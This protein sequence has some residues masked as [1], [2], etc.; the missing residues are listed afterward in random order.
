LALRRSGSLVNS[1]PQ[2]WVREGRER[3]EGRCAEGESDWALFLSIHTKVYHQGGGREEKG[4]RARDRTH[5][6]GRTYRIGFLCLFLLV[7]LEKWK[8]KGGRK[9]KEKG[10]GVHEQGNLQEGSFF[11]S[12]QAGKGKKKKKKKKGKGLGQISLST[13]AILP[14][15]SSVNII[16][17]G[18][19]KE[20]KRKREELQGTTPHFAFFLSTTTIF[21]AEK[22][23]RKKGGGLK[24]PQRAASCLLPLPAQRGGG[25][26]KRKKKCPWEPLGPGKVRNCTFFRATQTQRKGKGGEK[27][28]GKGS[29]D[30]RTSTNFFCVGG[31][32]KRKEKKAAPEPGNRPSGFWEWVLRY[33]YQRLVGKK[34]K[35]KGKKE[36]K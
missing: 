2:R 4:E 17:K 35:E 28:G 18:K 32:K 21:S 3:S 6:G 30:E 25:R 16:E 29:R 13:P 11:R 14:P 23:R 10:T 31:E 33:V 20:K 5:K 22:K 27:K 9:K 1:F 19:K 15:G 12:R 24:V 36:K 7:D 26:R 8:R 34:R